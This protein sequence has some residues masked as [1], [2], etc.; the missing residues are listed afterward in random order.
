VKNS[1]P[2]RIRHAMYDR[3][4]IFIIYYIYFFPPLYI[5]IMYYFSAIFCVLR[6]YLGRNRY[7]ILGLLPD[8]LLEQRFPTPHPIPPSSTLFPQRF[9]EIPEGYVSDVFICRRGRAG[10]RNPLFRSFNYYIV[11]NLI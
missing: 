1:H 7:I 11:A 8:L 2:N 10:R 4:D 6:P 5:Y 3:P 9:S